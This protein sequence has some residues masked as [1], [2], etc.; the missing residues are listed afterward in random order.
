MGRTSAGMRPIA[1]IPSRADAERAAALL[2]SAGV[3]RVLLFGSVAR[4]EATEDSD[5]DLVAIYDDLD[6]SEQFARERELSRLVADEIGHPVDVLVTDRPEWRARSENLLTSVECQV[7]G[8]GVTLADKGVGEV[9]WGKKM[10]IPTNGYEATVRCLREVESAL[11]ALHMYLKPG[12]AERAARRSVDAEKALYLTV[13]RF[14]G[15]CGQ[16]QRAV[17]SS[18]KALVHTAGRR[19]ELR[20]H[21]IGELCAALVEPYRGDINARVALVG[22]EEITRWHMDSR[23]TP[24]HEPDIPLTSERV[25]ALADVACKVASYIVANLDESVPNVRGVE[26]AVAL[27]EQHLDLYDLETGIALS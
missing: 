11:T 1:K 4:E 27:V 17:E 16:V 8:Y 14:E 18:V 26:S 9:D 21:D 10:V 13:L 2:V 23:Y 20:G 15:A 12:D 6:Y 25:W 19:R 24:D 22:V 5:V 3:S 7:S